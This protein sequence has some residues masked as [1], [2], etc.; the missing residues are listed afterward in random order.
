LL[1]WHT[2]HPI[3]SMA[4][5]R[6]TLELNSIQGKRGIW[7]CVPYQQGD[8]AHCFHCNLPSFF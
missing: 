2:R 8:F 5:A 4:A 6:A 3:P 1:K 7:F